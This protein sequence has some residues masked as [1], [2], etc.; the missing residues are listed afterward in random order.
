MASLCCNQAHIVFTVCHAIIV[1]HGLVQREKYIAHSLNKQ[2]IGVWQ[3]AILA[4]VTRGVRGEKIKY[5]FVY[6]TV[7]RLPVS[8]IQDGLHIAWV[9]GVADSNQRGGA[10]PFLGL[11]GGSGEGR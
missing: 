2:D 11:F 1:F 4:V 8:T 6:A 9:K 10:T 3:G 5:L 7:A